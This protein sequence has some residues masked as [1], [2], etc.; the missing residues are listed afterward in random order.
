DV[1]LPL[2][3]EE[4]FMRATGH[5]R[6]LQETHQFMQQYYSEL[7][8][9]RAA[10]TDDVS[11]KHQKHTNLR[12]RRCHLEG[13]CIQLGNVVRSL[14][15]MQ[16]KQQLQDMTEK[17]LNTIEKLE[18]E[19]GRLQK[20]Y[21]F[22]RLPF[23]IVSVQDEFQRRT[24]ETYEGLEGVAG[25]V[26]DILVFGKTKEEHDENLRAMLRWTRESG[27]KFNPDNCRIC[28]REVSY[29]GHKLTANGLEPDPLKV[30]AEL[31]TILGMVNYLAKFAPN[32]AEAVPENPWQTVATDL[33][34]WNSK[35]YVVICD[36]LSRYFEIERLHNITTA[37]V[38]HKN[39]SLWTVPPEK[40]RTI[41][42]LYANVKDAYRA[43]PLPPLGKSEHNLIFL[44]PQYK[45]LVLRQPITTPSFRVWSQEAE[46]ALKDC[47]DTTDWSVLLH[48]H[49]EDIEE[50]THYL[51]FCMDVAVPTKTVR[52][53]PNNKPWI[54]SEVKDILN[55]KKRAFKD[56]NW[57]ELKRVQGEL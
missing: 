16:E 32:L 13:V 19:I 43:T 1:A 22:L 34:T 38:I 28:V 24:D 46:E 53:F 27:L 40:N 31:E 52:C 23:G 33:L 51:N 20:K 54:T 17:A 57:T 48:P 6:T 25:I 35:N 9:K 45:P 8:T 11:K 56:R 42:L 4:F 30:K 49:G 3:M 7:I 5:G 37:A 41:D 55:Q 50:V 29:F 47:Y 44:Q 18:S 39:E 2:T 12:S 36:Y 26:D 10:L 14:Q 15:K 21:R